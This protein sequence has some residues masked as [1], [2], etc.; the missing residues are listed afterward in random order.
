MAQPLQVLVVDD[1]VPVLDELA[2][3][4]RRDRR[5]GE[6]RTASS[7]TEALQI[8]E[9]EAYDVVFLDIAM[10]GLSGLSVARVLARFREHAEGWRI[11]LGVMSLFVLYSVVR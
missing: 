4:L 11:A 6:V 10:P 1:E 3:L 9:S 8:L 2:F 5:V 7:G